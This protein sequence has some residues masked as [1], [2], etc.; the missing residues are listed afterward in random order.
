MWFAIATPLIFATYCKA[1]CTRNFSAYWISK[2]MT[3][4]SLFSDDIEAHSA[5]T[6]CC[7]NEKFIDDILR[8]TDSFKYLCTCVGGDGGDTH[9]GHHFKNTLTERLDDI[10]NCLFR[11]DASDDS[12]IDEIFC[13]LHN[14]IWVYSCCAISDEKCNMVDFA[15]IASFNYETNLG[16]SLLT[17]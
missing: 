12:L 10:A 3:L 17:N 9:L 15:Y 11:S 1:L 5:K 13:S 6:R 4:N 14:E 16:A 7:S 8:K 2:V